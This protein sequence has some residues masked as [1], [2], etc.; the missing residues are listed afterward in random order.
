MK[1]KCLVLSLISMVL[2]GAACVAQ[3]S[4]SNTPGPNNP[5]GRR[6]L[7]GRGRPMGAAA[8]MLGVLTDEQR[9]SFR[10]AMRAQRKE[11][12]ALDAELRTARTELFDAGIA[13]T[14]DEA[15]V[16]QKAMAVANL[17]A[18]LAVLRFK[19]I[20]RVQPPLSP[21]QIQR[22]KE[23]AQPGPRAGARPALE[24]ERPRS[25]THTN[26]DVNDLPPKQ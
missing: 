24:G 25:L 17:E 13:G 18:D 23:A 2:L 20:S 11:V 1:L 3:T 16:R 5:P 21:D 22:I 14:F 15:E 7:A 19:A 6:A 8:A 9:E 12:G 10:Q 4:D 26:R